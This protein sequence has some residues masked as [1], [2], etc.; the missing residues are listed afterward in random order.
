M[1]LALF[2][3][4][5]ISRCIIFDRAFENGMHVDKFLWRF[6]TASVD[7]IY[8]ESAVLRRIAQTSI[9]VHFIGCGIASGQNARKNDPPSGPTR[10]YYCGFRTALISQLPQSGNG[11]TISISHAPEVDIPAH[12]DV[13][14]IVD[15]ALS[16]NARATRRTDAGIALAEEFGTAEPHRCECDLVDDLHPIAQW[17]PNCLNGQIILPPI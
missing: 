17:G 15:P 1:C 5:E 8:Q 14:L 4:D 2:P 6:E 13:R 7:G 9:E 11:Y 10:R 12:V 16:R 3:N